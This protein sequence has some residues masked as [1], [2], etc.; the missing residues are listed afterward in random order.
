[1]AAIQTFR[2]PINMSGLEIQNFRLQFL[3]GQPAGVQEGWIW[4]SGLNKSPM[5]FDGTSAVSLDARL[6]TDIP[7]SALAV[8]PLD[9]A[10]H[11]GTQ[12]SSTISD[13]T[14]AA[15]GAASLMGLHEFA[16]PS[17]AVDMVGQTLTGLADPVLESDAV[18]QRA[19]NGELAALGDRY[20]AHTEGEINRVLAY[21]DAVIADFAANSDASSLVPLGW[22]QSY[23]DAAV[24]AGSAA[25]SAQKLA[26]AR[27]FS[28]A[29]VM[30]SAPVLFDGTAPVVLVTE[31]ADDAL[32]IAKTAGL[33]DAL[34]AKLS[35]SGGEMAGPLT[36]FNSNPED[37][38]HAASKG[39]VDN[40]VSSVAGAV[41]DLLTD[42]VGKLAT[43]RNF[44]IAGVVTAPAQA[45]DGTADV[46]FNTSVADNALTIANTDGLRDELD[47]LA[48]AIAVKQDGLDYTPVNVNGDI[49]TGALILAP[50]TDPADDEAV[51]RVYVDKVIQAATAGLDGKAEVRVSAASNVALTGL[52]KIDDV[53][54]EE[55]DSVLLI[56]QTN[57][58]ENG[59]WVAYA[60]GWERRA[61]ADQDALTT[62]ALTLV[63]EGTARSGRQYWLNTKGLIDV[64]V[65]PQSWV[66]FQVGK[67]YTASNGARLEGTDIRV[68]AG[69]GLEI[70][71]NAVQV[72]TDVVAR[73]AVANIGNGT[74]LV[75]TVP[76]NLGTRDICVTVRNT[77]TNQVEYLAWTATD[78]NTLTLE[79]VGTPPAQDG[80]RVLI[81]A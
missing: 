8:N 74:D 65:T 42:G 10:N 51:P 54:V 1:M 3:D 22:I 41:D 50:N 27:E 56:A 78:A 53:D 76:H 15:Q 44:S 69:P 48:N 71:G 47:N 61:D 64:G 25:E 30:T 45:F 32:T 66:T 37:E 67:T 60:A 16:P 70:A 81:I 73:R 26:T 9:R 80:Y 6:A 52:P 24:A 55:G 59:I 31:V 58:A 77:L 40:A 39:Y 12:V 36:L 20:V 34:D 19:L 43:A 5:Y 2:T 17:A 23:V 21:S 63:M 62:G 79:M 72:D 13:F 14:A 38:R 18:N 75:F 29:G 46:V 11:T 33:Q 35:K 68:N 57:P 49:M 7:L 28:L 4:Y